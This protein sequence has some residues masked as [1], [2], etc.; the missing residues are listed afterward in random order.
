MVL[1]YVRTKLVDELPGAHSEL[2]SRVLRLF[3]DPD[4]MQHSF[5]RGVAL[6]HRGARFV[7]QAVFA[8]F[9][10]DDEAHTQLAGLKG[11]QGIMPCLEC[12]NVTTIASEHLDDYLV[13]IDCGYAEKFD[14][15]TN[16]SIF[17]RADELQALFES[18]RKSDYERKSKVCGLKYVPHGLLYTQSLRGIYRPVDHCIADWMHMLCSGGVCGTEIGLF[19]HVLKAVANITLPLLNAWVCA[20]TLPK[21][22]GEIDPTWLSD[23]RLHDDTFQS[24]ASTILTLLPIILAFATDTVSTPSLADHIYCLGLLWEIVSILSLGPDDSMQHIDVLKGL[25]E[26][27]AKL[28]AVLYPS[29]AKPKFHHLMH[30]V[31]H[32]RYVGKILSC[33]VT[34]RLH[35]TSRKASLHV[36]RHM[37][38]TV[39]ADVV[40]RK[41]NQVRSDTNLYL[42]NFIV[43]ATPL[44]NEVSFS[45][46]CL[47]RCGEIFCNDIV[48]LRCDTVGKVVRCWEKH[49]SGEVVLELCPFAR[50]GVEAHIV[51][52]TMN[53]PSLFVPASMIIDACAWAYKEPGIIRVIL[54]RGARTPRT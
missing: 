17:E 45:D 30:L 49:A 19:L 1:G 47:L 54:P 46:R 53:A 42:T 26:A 13:N 11:A 18:N 50:R 6:V 2:M 15:H 36:F 48:W 38:H 32:A 20:F 24:L 39:L 12:K 31:K 7:V 27:H 37:E 43:N 4:P 10:A 9:L 22:H 33:F 34:E 21:K 25:I 5:T 35:K 29:A 40:N 28:F 23:R 51:V 8:G 44:N 14:P 16:D 41:C 3:F 52:E